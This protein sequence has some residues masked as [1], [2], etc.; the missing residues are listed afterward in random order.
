MSTQMEFPI[1]E[2]PGHHNLLQ[3]R[4]LTNQ[5]YSSEVSTLVWDCLVHHHRFECLL[6][7]KS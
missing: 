2:Q 3:G 4:L 1:S 5:S 6:G 7:R